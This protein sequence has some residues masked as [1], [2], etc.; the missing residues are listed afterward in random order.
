[1]FKHLVLIAAVGLAGC[2]EPEPPGPTSAST[3]QN[4]MQAHRYVIT[5]AQDETGAVSSERL[6][7]VVQALET[8]D[9]VSIEA[10]DGLPTIIVTATPDAIRA[11]QETGFVAAVQA[12]GL[13]APQ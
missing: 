8:H 7:A 3:G 6:D 13:S 1:M 5:V 10:L 2:S 12:D 9:A 4:D 11:A